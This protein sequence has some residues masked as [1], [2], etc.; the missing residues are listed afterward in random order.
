MAAKKQKVGGFISLRFPEDV[1]TEKVPAYIRFTPQTVIYGGTE[2]LAPVNKPSLSYGA[3]TPNRST[4]GGILEQVRRRVD[5]VVDSFSTAARSAINSVSGIFGSGATFSSSIGQLSRVVSGSIR[6]GDFNIS[7]GQ[8]TKPDQL[9]TEGS[10]NLFLPEGLVTASSVA[11][12]RIEGAAMAAGVDA[13]NGDLSLDSLKKVAG[14]VASDMIRSS[15]MLSGLM[16]QTTGKIMNNFTF[17]VFNG[18]NHRNFEYTFTL[19]PKNEKE[20]EEAK[21]ICDTFLFLMLP[22]RSNQSGVQFYEIPCQW[23]IEYQ[24]LGKTLEYFQQ[25]NACFLQ[26]VSVEYNGNTGSALHTDG[27]PLQTRLSLSFIEIE[28]LYRKGDLLTQDVKK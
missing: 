27:S 3:G 25:P 4:G 24:M 21:K 26:N 6:I 23:K 2:G 13:A 19:V 7:L 28:P 9:R 16:A 1:G 17:Q 11:Y 5:G 15:G 18:V 12:D 20:A 14:G 22:G 8:K 10:I